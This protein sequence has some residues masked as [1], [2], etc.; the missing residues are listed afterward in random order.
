ML[1]NYFIHIYTYH[2]KNIIYSIY[3]HGHRKTSKKPTLHRNTD[4]DLGKQGN[5]SRIIPELG[6]SISARTL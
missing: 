5:L 4:Y 3:L 2:S 1:N 6:K